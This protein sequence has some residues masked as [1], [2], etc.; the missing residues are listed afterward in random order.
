MRKANVRSRMLR[1]P[2]S[3]VWVSALFAVVAMAG[4]ALAA[5]VITIGF[6]GAENPSVI[7]IRGD[8][9]LTYE[10]RENP[11]DRQVVIELQGA[12]MSR[13]ALRKIDTS[14]FNSNVLM[15]SPY[16]VDGSPGTA[17]VVI[18]LRKSVQTEVSQEGNVIR[19]KVPSVAKSA[20]LAPVTDAPSDSAAAAPAESASESSADS[21]SVS[22]SAATGASEIKEPAAS[23]SAPMDAETE[24]SPGS[25]RLREF[26]TSRKTSTFKGRPITLQVR[27]MEAAD[28]F[29]MIGEASGFNIIL[30]ENVRGKVT[31]SLVDVPWDQA[32][33]VVLQTLGLGA[34][35]NRNILRIM[36]M[37]ALTEEKIAELKAAQLA[38]ATTPRLTRIFPVNYAKIDELAKIL[39]SIQDSFNSHQGDE[40][41]RLAGGANAVGGAAAAGGGG[42]MENV[43]LT[44]SRTNR[45]IVRDI[46]ENL[47]RIGKLIAVLDTQTPQVMIEGKIVEASEVAS[48][49]IS[50][51]FGSELTGTPE[52][53]IAWAGGLN[54]D[55]A[56][57]SST[58]LSSVATASAGTTPGGAVG[59]SFLPGGARLSSM[60]SLLESES[61]LK[62]VS[63]PKTVVLN[64][65][66]ASVMQ[67]FPTAVPVVTISATGPTTTYET[68]EAK[69]SLDVTPTVTDDGNVRLD[70][71]LR[72]DII[73]NAGNNQRAVAQRDIKT[74]VVVDSGT[75]LVIGGIYI[76]NETENESG[77][78]FFRKL[79]IL[80]ALFSSTAKETQR[81]ELLF[82]VTPTVLNA[83]RAGV[84]AGT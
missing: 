79:P 40:V 15:I 11:D 48:R 84:G 3:G 25:A 14:S 22:S 4:D 61:K 59:L 45:L 80:G 6:K 47:D 27:D 26:E 54:I 10:K 32:L 31:L 83:K 55:R 7:E 2:L 33:D 73:D 70:L 39:T 9:P 41:L 35:R 16:M 72:R 74:Q 1:N 23:A 53:S 36:P 76:I 64:R 38:K 37:S 57:G 75:T 63:S 49:A 19:V 82:F 66:R 69:L 44:D 67:S 30:S 46:P 21:M 28:V 78:P 71:D 60:L 29:R 34:D 68:K 42:K 18:Q 58:L 13:M 62:L 17:R 81:R 51:V 5:K 65:E 12:S 8:G 56:N 52:A 50:G 24:N 20:V 43:V 77:I